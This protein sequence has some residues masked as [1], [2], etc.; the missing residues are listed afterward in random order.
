MALSNNRTPSAGTVT[1]LVSILRYNFSNC[2]LYPDHRRDLPTRLQNPTSLSSSE[3]LMTR[4]SGFP[5]VS[6]GFRVD[7]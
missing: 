4:T 1:G 7:G 5:R 6:Y 2:S 3:T